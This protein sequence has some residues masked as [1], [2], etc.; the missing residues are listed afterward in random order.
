MQITLNRPS[1]NQVKLASKVFFASAATVALGLGLAHKATAVEEIPFKV[2]KKEKDFELRQYAPFILAETEVTS[3]FEDAGELA[4]KR[5][6]KYIS[7]DNRSPEWAKSQ[8]EHVDTVAEISED[9]TPESDHDSEPQG[10]KIDMTAPVFQQESEENTHLVSFVLP[11]SYSL[12]EAPIPKNE[13]VTIREVPE[14][15]MAAIRYSGKWSQANYE[16][17]LEQLTHALEEAG[18][19]VIGDPMYARY[20]SPYSPRFMRRNEILLEVNKPPLEKGNMW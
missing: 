12:S 14:K 3:R 15:T 4:F 6:F 5:L 2:L 17:H 19:E 18:Y 10:Q 9:P 16:K 7:G 1:K 11:P 8:I 20:N 13:K